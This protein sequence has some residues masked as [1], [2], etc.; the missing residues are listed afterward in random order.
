MSLKPGSPQRSVLLI[1]DDTSLA[2]SLREFLEEEGWEVDY[3]STVKEGRAK[4]IGKVFDLVVADYLLPDATVLSLFEE[5]QLRSPLTKV[6][7]ITG[8]QDVQVAAKAFRKGAGDFLFKP[9]NLDELQK[10]IAGLMEERRRESER[11]RFK[12]QPGHPHRSSRMI[13]RSPAVEKVF[14]LIDLVAEKNTTVLVTGESGT[15][16]E[17]VARGIH[18]R[19]LRKSHPFVAINCAAIPE[20]L[21]ED[22]LFGHVKGAYTDAGKDRTGKFERA[23][24]GTLLLDE[25]GDM[26][27]SLQMKLLRVLENKRFEKLGS[28]QTIQVDVRIVVA[29]NCDLREKVRN[30]EFREDLFYRLNVVPIHLPPLRERKEDLPL[31]AGHFLKEFSETYELP[32]KKLPPGVLKRLMRYDWPG[33]IRELKNVLELAC[34]LSGDE[35]TIL[36]LGDFATLDNQPSGDLAPTELLQGYLRLPEEGLEIQEVVRSVEN[37]LIQEALQRTG[38][39]KRK[40]AGL[41]GL[42]RTTLVAKLRRAADSSLS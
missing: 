1:E 40:A 9:F 27:A 3:A 7:V 33:N 21:L 14:Q 37:N 8:V 22:E 34:V 25:I 28:N 36:E 29:T 2:D 20:S 11:E 26:P 13:G 10:C 17:L 23:D 31:L 18:S 12:N 42:K 39:N 41:L 32:E 15:G 38:G 35:R 16:K 30:G 24:Q 4:L 6:L 19:S 5:V